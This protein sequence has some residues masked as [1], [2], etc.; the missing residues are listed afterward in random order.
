MLKLKNSS[1][2]KL[3]KRFNMNKA[4]LMYAIKFIFVEYI[5]QSKRNE[6]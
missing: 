3:I 4:Y 2:I 1:K 6:N 5:Y